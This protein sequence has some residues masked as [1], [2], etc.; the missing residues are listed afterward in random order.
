MSKRSKKAL[1]HDRDIT[2]TIPGYECDIPGEY[3]SSTGPVNK[4]PP[5]WKHFDSA[6]NDWTP[7]PEQL[8]T[9]PQTA[10]PYI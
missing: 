4:L 9:L 2:G 6:V 10:T 5:L 8:M 7:T 1:G 3:W